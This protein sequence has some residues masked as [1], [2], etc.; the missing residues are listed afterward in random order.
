MMFAKIENG[1]SGDAP[2]SSGPQAGAEATSDGVVVEMD[3]T[4]TPTE[5]GNTLQLRQTNSNLGIVMRS[6]SIGFQAERVASLSTSA[7]AERE[8]SF[9]AESSAS[10]LSRILA[11]YGLL[12]CLL[13]CTLAFPIMY[14]VFS[15]VFP[16]GERK[17]ESVESAN[18]DEPVVSCHDMY[19][20]LMLISG[21]VQ[22]AFV[23]QE[24][25]SGWL[26][27]R[28]EPCPGPADDVQKIPIFHCLVCNVAKKIV[29]VK[30][31]FTLALLVIN[32][33][34]WYYLFES[35]KECGEKLWNF[36]LTTFALFFV[37]LASVTASTPKTGKL[38]MPTGGYMNYRSPSYCAAIAEGRGYIPK[39]EDQYD[40]FVNAALSGRLAEVKQG[41]SKGINVNVVVDDRGCTALMH[42]T[43][44]QHT[45]VVS[46]LLAAC[47]Q[48]D[49][50]DNM[51]GQTALMH[52]SEGL[53]QGHTEIAAV[54]IAAGANVDLQCKE[55][56]RTALM[57]ACAG[58]TIKYMPQTCTGPTIYDVRYDVEPLTDQQQTV[59]AL[60]A[61]GAKID[62]QDKQSGATAL[63]LAARQETPEN[64]AA[65]LAA[66]AKTELQDTDGWTALMFAAANGSLPAV[67]ALLAAGADADIKNKEG[68]TARDL[69]QDRHKDAIQA[70]LD[71]PVWYVTKARTTNARTNTH[72]STQQ[73]R[74]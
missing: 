57:Y 68:K 8:V 3:G 12:L 64:L 1:N 52:A 33:M 17:D 16:W 5:S 62:T 14:I 53:G 59:S 19:P 49:L 39:V 71:D 47:A 27:A 66:G 74:E 41:L 13:A 56:G 26:L 28:R 42:A 61:A 51:N 18:Q 50:Q 36:G 73:T 22:L 32:F 70:L 29:V 9:T 34:M 20:H 55:L 4:D 46:E 23:F 58:P 11:L 38:P 65:L 7:P 54:L 25:V 31:S 37:N 67:Q 15:Q 48:M 35:A 45:E 10:S 6:M 21:C 72:T 30:R 2:D 69:A 43:A 60:L 24:V 44:N 40:A 63:M